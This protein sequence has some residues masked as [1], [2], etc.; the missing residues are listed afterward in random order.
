MS[1]RHNGIL[2]VCRVHA[3]PVHAVHAVFWIVVPTRSNQAPPMGNP[4]VRTPMP[5]G[6]KLPCICNA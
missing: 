3:H 4:L 6:P 1:G 5:D 2:R